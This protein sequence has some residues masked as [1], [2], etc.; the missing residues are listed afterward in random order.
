MV[1]GIPRLDLQ[2][3]S[4]ICFLLFGIVRF[5]RVWNCN[6]NRCRWVRV[7]FCGV[8]IYL[9][10]GLQDEHQDSSLC[11]SFSSRNDSP[12][13][14]FRP[15]FSTIQIGKYAHLHIQYRDCLYTN[16]SFGI[17]GH[18][19]ITGIGSLPGNYRFAFSWFSVL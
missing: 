11:I 2:I 19:S 14:H 17:Y 16:A 3:R 6:R 15:F 8:L 1:N 10:F 7:I 18:S 13:S 9:L 4:L 5:F 12:S